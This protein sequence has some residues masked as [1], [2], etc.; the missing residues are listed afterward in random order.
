MTGWVGRDVTGTGRTGNR[1]VQHDRGD[2][3]RGNASVSVNRDGKRGVRA[4]EV[5]RARR[6]SVGV[7]LE[8]A[9]TEMRRITAPC[10]ADAGRSGQGIVETVA[11]PPGVRVDEPFEVDHCVRRSRREDRD[12]ASATDTDLDQIG[13]DLAG[14]EVE[15]G[16]CRPTLAGRKHGEKPRAL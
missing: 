3:R 10:V 13:N 6:R 15:I 16:S 7:A 5:V 2:P 11:N 4:D 8:V 1:H 12:I 14:L 9:I